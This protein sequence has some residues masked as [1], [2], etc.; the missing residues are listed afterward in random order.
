MH[1]P[2]FFHYPYVNEDSA[3]SF[4]SVRI[5]TSTLQQS[6]AIKVLS[7]AMLPASILPAVLIIANMGSKHHPLQGFAPPIF[8]DN[9]HNL[10]ETAVAI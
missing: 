9:A 7:T 5:L 2:A 3:V 6:P 10:H 4:C 8:L 1:F